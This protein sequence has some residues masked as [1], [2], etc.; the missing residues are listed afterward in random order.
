[1]KKTS[2]LL[3]LLACFV[4]AGCQEA[5]IKQSSRGN[6]LFVA[7]ESTGS[8]SDS[9]DVNVEDEAAKYTEE[10]RALLSKVYDYYQAAKALKLSVEVKDETGSVR[11]VQT[12]Q[13]VYDNGTLK[14]YVADYE[15]QAGEQSQRFST[16]YD[17]SKHYVMAPG[18]KWQEGANV[19]T[20]TVY[21]ALIDL[22][23]GGKDNLNLDQG[24]SQPMMTKKITDPEQL[25][26]LRGYVDLPVVLTPQAE[27]TAEANYQIDAETGRI[28]TVGL[29]IGVT[30]LGQT[31]QYKV[32]L[33][34]TELEEADSVAKVDLEAEPIAVEA[35]AD[36]DALSRF[37]AANPVAAVTNYELIW[38]QQSGDDTAQ[39]WRQYVSRHQSD[40]QAVAE[41]E[42][43]DKTEQAYQL[44]M[45][46]K[47]WVLD[48]A[49]E[50]TSQEATLSDMYAEYVQAFI[51]QYDQL[52]PV[53]TEA[54][55]AKST[56]YRLEFEN[57]PEAFKAAAGSMNTT[58]LVRDKEALY[59]LEYVVNK[60][61]SQLE[62][63]YFWSVTAEDDKVRYINSLRFGQIN[64]LPARLWEVLVDAKIWE[65]VK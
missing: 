11:Q 4:L 57:D 18:T 53:E 26:Q 47:R 1:M 39:I 49:G 64:Q 25:K 35:S 22:L 40:A 31:S 17:G 50:V 9:A 45:A 41:T 24:V 5:D 32:W 20:A 46:G 3:S 10:Q 36:S 19:K 59:R 48:E 2:V 6:P 13:E 23:L 51:N 60:Q 34:T 29:N 44:L 42:I 14:R 65:A 38:A 28:L 15:T 63:V 21:H 37:K 43:K 61:T 30:D 12:N 16:Y 62:E 52:K 27:L 8:G 56:T 33:D 54:D 55:D 58:N 7:E